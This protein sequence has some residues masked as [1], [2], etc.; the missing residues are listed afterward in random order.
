MR[1]KHFFKTWRQYCDGD[2]REF[3]FLTVHESKK[4]ARST[5]VHLGKTEIERVALVLRKLVYIGF[6]KNS[7]FCKQTLKKTIKD[8]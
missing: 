7:R 8:V 1:E 3:N 4:L 2:V 5:I 6:A